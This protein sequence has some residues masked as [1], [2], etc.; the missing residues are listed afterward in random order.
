MLIEVDGPF[1]LASTLESGQVFR[2]PKVGDRYEGVVFNNLVKVRRVNGGVEFS[3]GPDSDRDVAPLLQDYLGLGTDLAAV[4]R[5]ISIDGRV[6]ASID[7]YPGMRVLRQ[8]PWECL[9][10][11]ICS[12]ASNIPRITR[13]VE[14]MCSAFGRPIEFAGTTRK[15]FPTPEDLAEAGEK[16]I[17]KLGL[18]YR[19]GYLARTARTIADG[20]LDLMAL[21]EDDYQHALDAL[22]ELDGVGDKVANCVLLFSLDKP[23]AFPV[24][25][26][27][28]R[29][30]KEWYFDGS[31]T[32]MPLK[33]MRLW[34]HEHFGQYAGYAN[35]YLF[36]DRRLMGRVR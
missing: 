2:W 29:A 1:D 8:D 35:Q 36:H 15:T 34:A 17:F 10:C 28:Q 4:Y 22:T 13:N 5:A 21:R 3:A 32:K 12:S 24:D 18:G 30:L 16:R 26:W 6:A 27:I 11:F 23:E 20:K 19:A 33:R 9:V 31:A 7:R 25:V 14:D